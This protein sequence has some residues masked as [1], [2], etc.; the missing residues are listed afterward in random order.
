MPSCM[1]N[2]HESQKVNLLVQ[3]S[4]IRTVMVK[5]LQGTTT[6]IFFVSVSV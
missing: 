3:R 6:W 4:A 5:V 1:N 2:I